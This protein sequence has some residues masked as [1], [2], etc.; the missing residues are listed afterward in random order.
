M[1]QLKIQRHNKEIR[2]MKKCVWIFLTLTI[3]QLLTSKTFRRIF[4]PD[5]NF[6]ITFVFSTSN[7]IWNQKLHMQWCSLRWKTCSKQRIALNNQPHS[8]VENADFSPFNYCMSW[9]CLNWSFAAKFVTVYDSNFMLL[10]LLK[11]LQETFGAL[12]SILWS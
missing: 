9:H 6:Q 8:L 11:I 3:W 4:S 1:A 10:W 12:I 7:A 2:K 5:Q